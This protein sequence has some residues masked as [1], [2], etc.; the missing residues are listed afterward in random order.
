MGACDLHSG[1][2]QKA[3]VTCPN[4]E[5]I[6]IRVENSSDISFESFQVNFDGQTESFGPL[7][8]GSVSEYRDISA[9]YRYAYTEALSGDRRFIL[10]PIDFV[11]E[12]HLPPGTYTYRYSV[13]LLDEPKIKDDWRL[14]G[15]MSVRLIV[16][17]KEQA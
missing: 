6:C 2:H 16:I 5:L 17:D 10:Q 13:G 8:A 1:D 15:Y 4:P 7:A 3:P 11:G 9:A 14:D 12:K